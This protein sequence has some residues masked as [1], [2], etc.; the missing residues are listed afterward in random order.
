MTVT[1]LKKLLDQLPPQCAEFRVDF[2]VKVDQQGPAKLSR[3]D[4]PISSSVIDWQTQEVLLM[5]NETFTKLQ[6]YA[7]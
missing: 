1:D 5:T 4:H 7:K 3:E 2:T 6:D